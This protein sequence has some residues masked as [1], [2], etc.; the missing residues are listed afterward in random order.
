MR[1]AVTGGGSGGHLFPALAV[2]EEL[3]RRGHEV[4]FVGGDGLEARVVP[5]RLPFYPIATGKLDR[6][7]PRPGELLRAGKGLLQGL[8]LA[9]RLRPRVVFATGGYAS[10]PFALAASLR[11]SR[12]FIHEQNA[13]LGLANR[14]L[15][16]RAQEVLLAVPADL[17]LRVAVKSRVV[18][19]P[20]REERYPA[21]EARR[22][23]GLDPDLPTLLVL[24]GSQ[25]ARALNQRLPRLLEPFLDRLQVL[26]QTGE[27]WLEETASLVSHPRYHLAGF[28]DAALA[29]SAADLA[30]TRAGAMTLA[31]IAFHRVPAILVPYPYSAGGHQRRNAGLYA[32]RGAAL[33]VEEEELDSLPEKLA[34]LLDPK[35]REG[36]RRALV[37]FDPKGSTRRIADLLEEAA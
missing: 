1:V 27:R 2:G 22:R 11:G 14:I 4:F 19:M 16:E 33:M 34:A 18:G 25:G 24:G 17:P 26:H 36:M 10:L 20:V 23:L 21:A 32:S 12:L 35:T 15:A 30:V 7:R 6:G 28:L 29:W 13:Q 31:E 5:G 3:A 9:G 37:E 8:A